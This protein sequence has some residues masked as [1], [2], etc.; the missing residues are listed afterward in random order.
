MRR[1]QTGPAV[2]KAVREPVTASIGLLCAGWDLLRRDPRAEAVLLICKAA[3]EEP[4]GEHGPGFWAVCQPRR[5]GPGSLP[6]GSACHDVL[7]RVPRAEQPDQETRL[8]S[9]RPGS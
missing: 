8:A 2:P 3:G 7:G 5:G 6:D 1:A 9:G 4:V